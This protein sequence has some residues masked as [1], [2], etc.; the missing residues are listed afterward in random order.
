[1][2]AVYTFS[3]RSSHKRTGFTLNIYQVLGLVVTAF[4]LILLLV[5]GYLLVREY[6]KVHRLQQEVALLQ[7]ETRALG[8]QYQA[9]T[10]KEVVFKKAKLLGLHPPKKEQI[11]KIKYR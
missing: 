10:S 5:G 9:L 11:V 2:A 1:M 8:A 4:L 7:R 3:P 6:A